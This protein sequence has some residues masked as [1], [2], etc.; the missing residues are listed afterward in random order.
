MIT[1]SAP[2][3]GAAK[4]DCRHRPQARYIQRVCR[5]DASRPTRNDDHIRLVRYADRS[6][7]FFTSCELLLELALARNQLPHI[8]DIETPT[9]RKIIQGWDRSERYE[10]NVTDGDG[11]EILFRLS[12][13]TLGEGYDAYLLLL[14]DADDFGGNVRALQI[15]GIVIALAIGACF[16]PA[17]WLFGGGMSASLKRI[18]AQAG[19]LRN[20]LPL[21]ERP[22]SSRIV[23]NTT[24]CRHDD[25]RPAYHLVVRAICA[26]GHR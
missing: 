21:S 12:R 4:G 5:A 7:R 20:L 22:I 6:P 26:K 10:G 24:A 14:A 18:T 3:R 23:R 16:I 25:A 13:L 15:K 1:L 19:Q 2:L 9:I 17:A 8:T 11:N